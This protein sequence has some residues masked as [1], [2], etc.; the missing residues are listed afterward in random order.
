MGFMWVQVVSSE[1]AREAAQQEALPPD[2]DVGLR[3]EGWEARTGLEGKRGC[4]ALK[5]ECR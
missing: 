1:Q 3:R 5:A 2:K 4:Q